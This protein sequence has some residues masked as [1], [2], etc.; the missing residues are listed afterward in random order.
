MKLRVDAPGLHC[1]SVKG[2]VMLLHVCTQ[3]FPGLHAPC[4]S[5][6]LSIKMQIPLP[7]VD[8]TKTEK[9]NKKKK[10]ERVKPIQWD[11]QRNV[12][13]RSVMY[14]YAFRNSSVCEHFCCWEREI[15]RT[16]RL[17]ITSR[18]TLACRRCRS[19]AHRSREKPSH[20]RPN[21]ARGKVE[22]ERRKE[23]TMRRTEE[24]VRTPAAIILSFWRAQRK[25]GDEYGRSS[26]HSHT[27]FLLLSLPPQWILSPPCSH[28]Q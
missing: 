10:T 11:I 9:K 17:S 3:T 15:Y 8:R 26:S 27:T 6:T 16:R 5:R 18:C 1:H 7:T 4:T 20:H 28:F 12:L 19:L 2:T 13:R 24:R 14:I 21:K 25:K 23:Y 22:S